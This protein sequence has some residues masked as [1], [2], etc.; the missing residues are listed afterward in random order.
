MESNIGVESSFGSL[1]IT[2]DDLASSITDVFSKPAKEVAIQ[3]AVV[4]KYKPLNTGLD[5]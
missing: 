1:Q 4:N 2:A 5:F 3:D